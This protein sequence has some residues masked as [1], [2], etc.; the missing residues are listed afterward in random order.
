MRARGNSDGLSQALFGT[1]RGNSAT[2][3]QVP[4]T[5]PGVVNVIPRRPS[6]FERLGRG[7]SDLTLL[8]KGLLATAV[9]TIVAGGAYAG[10]RP[11]RST[12]VDAC[13][14]SSYRLPQGVVPRAYHVTWRPDFA[15]PFNLQGESVIDVDVTGGGP[16]SCIVLHAGEGMSYSG[17]SVDVASAGGAVGRVRGEGGEHHFAGPQAVTKYARQVENQQL[18]LYLPAPVSVGARLRIDLNFTVPLGRTN[19]GVYLSSYTGDGGGTVYMVASQFEATFARS[20]FPCFD[21]PAMKANFTVTLDGIPA[22]YT[23]LSNMPQAPGTQV[24]NADGTS[25]TTFLPTPPMST[26]LLAMA[27]GPLISVSA[28][29][30][31]RNMP[32]NVYAVQKAGNADKIAYALQAG[33]AI[34]TYYEQLFSIPF[35][36][37]KMDMIAIPDFAAGAMENWGLITYRE[38][39]LLANTTTSSASEL[40]RVAVVVSHELAHQWFG[41]IVT[42]NW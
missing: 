20:S 15:A 29:T 14:W 7:L 12:G 39:A 30:G 19:T 3:G 40:Q 5:D 13:T 28:T 9:V 18:I 35:P 23:P 2:Y 38:T 42:M 33:A 32:L 25:R 21:E 10:T 26:Y 4:S 31:S 41:D 22:G 37:P 6:L 17:I 34:I 27:I 11:P 1:A 8:Q 24:L 16:W 36:L